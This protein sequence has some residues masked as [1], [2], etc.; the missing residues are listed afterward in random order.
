MVIKKPSLGRGLSALLGQPVTTSRIDET[1][2]SQRPDELLLKLPVDLG[3]GLRPI[4]DPELRAC[5]E[6]L[7]GALAAT[8]GPPVVGSGE[9]ER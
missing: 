8:S 1:P 9:S 7:A 2:A 4:G 5:L 6:S 3:G